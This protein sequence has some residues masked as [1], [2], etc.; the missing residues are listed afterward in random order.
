MPNQNKLSRTANYRSVICFADK[1]KL[2]KK[3]MICKK[4]NCNL[5]IRCLQSPYSYEIVL[6]VFH[7]LLISTFIMAQFIQIIPV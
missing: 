4:V 3:K 7:W 6:T 5:I 2:R 1:L